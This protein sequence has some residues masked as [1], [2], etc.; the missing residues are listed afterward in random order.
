MDLGVLPQGEGAREGGQSLGSL[1]INGCHSI[2]VQTKASG[3]GRKLV[4]SFIWGPPNLFWVK[5]CPS[6]DMLMACRGSGS[7]YE[8]PACKWGLHY[9]VPGLY[10]CA[11]RLDEIL[12]VFS[13][14]E[15]NASWNGQEIPFFLKGP[16]KIRKKITAYKRATPYCISSPGMVV[17]MA[18]WRGTGPRARGFLLNP[19]QSWAL[20][21][22]TVLPPAC[23]G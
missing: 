20:W 16:W 7:M 9:L 2:L 10:V 23:C 13:L 6:L 8:E 4:C 15:K 18:Q 3:R 21:A 12:K 11:S 5:S 14:E 19:D 1:F 22:V 17:S